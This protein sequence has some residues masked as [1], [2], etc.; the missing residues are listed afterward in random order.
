L[1]SAASGLQH[2]LVLHYSAINVPAHKTKGSVERLSRQME[3]VEEE[4]D[5]IRDELEGL[6]R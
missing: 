1:H 2:E 5:A 4:L 3:K 6:E